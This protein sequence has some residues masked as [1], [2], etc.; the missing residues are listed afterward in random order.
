MERH[1][2]H[3]GMAACVHRRQMRERGAG[4]EEA[5]ADIPS[6]LWCL[7]REGRP[8]RAAP[9]HQPSGSQFSAKRPEDPFMLETNLPCPGGTFQ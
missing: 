3:K 1:G 2:G 4:G 9:E 6:S 8:N 5:G 7:A